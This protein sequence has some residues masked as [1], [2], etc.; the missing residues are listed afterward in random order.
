[1]NEPTITLTMIVRNET[2]S[3]RNCLRS[4]SAQVDEIVIVDTGSTDDTMDIAREFTEKVSSFP[5]QEDF[6]A[7]R[8]Y[9]LQ[10]ATGDWILSLDADEELVCQAADDQQLDK[11]L[12]L[13]LSQPLKSLIMQNPTIEAFLLPLDNPVSNSGE[14]NRYYVLRLFKNNGK[15][16]FSGQIHEQVSVSEPEVV[17]IAEEP[18]IRHALLTGREY[19]RKRGRNLAVLK[20]ALAKDPDNNFL[21]YYLGLEWLMLGKPEQALPLLKA[22]YEN[23]TDDYL[24]FRAPAL[25]HLLIC[26]HALGRLEE[27][28]CL[29]LEADLRYPEYTDIYYLAGVFFE[30]LR[31]YTLAAK[32][33]AQALKGGN[34]P[35][36]FSH[37]NGSESFL[38]RYHLGHCY[39]MLGRLEQAQLE[40]EQ[41]LALNPKYLYPAYNLFAIMLLESGPRPTFEYFS[42][43][44]GFS[45]TIDFSLTMANL[46]YISGYPDLARQFLEKHHLADSSK[47]KLPQSK[48]DEFSLAFA[49][50]SILSGYLAEGKD[51]LREIAE[52]SSFY[53]RAVRVGALAA[54]LSGDLVGAGKLALKLW[55][56]KPTR[57]EGYLLLT[58]IHLLQ[59]QT[60][61][62]HSYPRQ[63]CGTN[64]ADQAMDLLNELGT[65]LP[66]KS[67]A[68]QQAASLKAHD[69]DEINRHYACLL[70][71]LT[72]FILTLPSSEEELER[73]DQR[74]S[75]T[76]LKIHGYYQEKAQAAAYLLARKFDYK[77]ET[78]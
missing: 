21:K 68:P 64:V 9:A 52:T 34:P 19:N 31:E 38:A 50:Y 77:G 10:M 8:N 22:A 63:I 41:A 25:R 53:P 37:I 70:E 39:E 16:R 69:T 60:P 46:F 26:L 18:L 54:L 24:L 56:C 65:F 47:P 71:A 67:W 48:L 6:S 58:L 51:Q 30:E 12:N 20:K 17:G 35:P 1:M 28:I 32:W 59:N 13:Q 78:T 66:S 43:A 33:F 11:Q 4:V 73:P 61:I 15:Y 27:G 5:W 29:C 36:V 2:R 57:C 75:Y 74:G 76:C 62:T 49:K 45:P 23:L 42:S 44:M 72:S 40:Y 3:L 7:A 14:Y 55:A